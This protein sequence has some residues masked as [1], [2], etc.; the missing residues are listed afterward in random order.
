MLRAVWDVS[1]LLAGC[2]GQMQ[3][4][5]VQATMPFDVRDYRIFG[6]YK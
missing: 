6:P 4:T 5:I 1:N 3:L 2:E